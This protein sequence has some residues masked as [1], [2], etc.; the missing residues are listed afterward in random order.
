[1]LIYIK[2][3]KTVVFKRI[4]KISLIFI[5]IAFT[6]GLDKNMNQYNATDADKV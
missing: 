3:K 2:K 1:M 5:I 4:N 6:A